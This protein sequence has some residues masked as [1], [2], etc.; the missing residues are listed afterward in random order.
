MADLNETHT[1]LVTVWTPGNG[2]PDALFEKG[3]WM[4]MARCST[5]MRA[6]EV[7]ICL[8]LRH[9]QGVQVGEMVSD[10]RGTRFVG[11]KFIPESSKNNK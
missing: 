2:K 4:E 1:F 5:K 11:Y 3:W 9:P 10:E 6:E 7:A 8:S